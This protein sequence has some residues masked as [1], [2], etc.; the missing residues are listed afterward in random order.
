M[1]SVVRSVALARVP[2][3][4][5]RV[6]PMVSVAA[7]LVASA[8][9]GFSRPFRSNQNTYLLHAVGPSLP[10][11]SDDW[12]LHTTD[13]FPVFTAVAGLAGGTIGFAIESFVLTLA[14]F[15]GLYLIASTLLLAAPR[16]VRSAV[17][18]LAVLLLSAA[19][20]LLP[21]THV[22]VLS[23]VHAFHGLG[24]QYLMSVPSMFQPSDCGALMLLAAGIGVWAATSRWRRPLWLVAGALAVGAC[25][26]HT[27]YLA[28]LAVALLA[29]A[30]ADLVTCRTMR[31]F[32]WYA[33][34]G[35][36]AVAVVLATS[37]V[38]RRSLTH[39]A[40][41]PQRYLAF[42]RIP[43]HTLVSHWDPHDAFLAVIVIAG[44]GLTVRL[45]HAWWAAMV[46]G[47]C[48]TVAAV[49]ALTVEVTRN[50][51]L[52][53]MFPWRITVFL[54]PIATLTGIVWLLRP[55]A[56]RLQNV[57]AVLLPVAACMSLVCLGIG[58]YLT[59][60]APDPASQSPVRAVRAASPAGVGLIPLELENVRLN[61]P[62]AV[63]VDMKSHPYTPSD[64]AEWQRRI[65]AARTAETG[66]GAFCRLIRQARI[67]WVILRPGRAVP[68][69]IVGWR[70]ASSD[71]VRIY[72]RQ[73][74]YYIR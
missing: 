36:A 41:E 2:N 43:H 17:P 5:N 9:V 34:V 44:A 21:Q 67:G 62:A 15:T 50:V 19:C 35:A 56:E 11:L 22:P 63:Y 20:Y 14:A 24:G 32:G 12:F 48:L 13:P 54:V 27:A 8:G 69:C 58:T 6:W 74:S 4:S 37:P 25:A 3:R 61:A 47:A 45:T 51:A 46:L 65:V 10:Q 49:T 1:S 7:V 52:A 72:I 70:P 38:A 55:I 40:G 60:N 33:G 26:L 18:P 57:R 28:P 30:V 68:A 66:D 53:M 64:L 31:R 16:T 71:G 59:V 23:W 39:G 73:D 29:F 42:E